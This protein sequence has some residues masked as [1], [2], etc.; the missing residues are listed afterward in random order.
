MATCEKCGNE[1]GAPFTFL[2]GV[3]ASSSRIEGSVTTTTTT[4]EVRGNE[5]AAI[6]DRCLAEHRRSKLRF[7]L[8]IG[9]IGLV[10]GLVSLVLYLPAGGEND[11]R[12]LAGISAIIGGAVLVMALAMLW[13]NGRS[14]KRDWFGEELGIE[15][16]R[17]KLE[18][19]GF[20]DFWTQKGWENT[21]KTL[22]R[23]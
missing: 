16:R 2:Y 19:A 14:R 15:V 5:T 13:E 6:G 8:I 9:A 7:W 3:S 17:P 23:T 21:R 18:E 11:P 20:T 4:Y 10:V 1:P 22:S 12:H